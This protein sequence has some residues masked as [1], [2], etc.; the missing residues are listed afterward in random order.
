MVKHLLLS[1]NVVDQSAQLV[2]VIQW[3]VK[4]TVL[5]M[6]QIV[7][8]IVNKVIQFAH[9]IAPIA[10]MI[11]L[12]YN[13]MRI[14]IYKWMEAVTENVRIFI[15]LAILLPF[16]VHNVFPFAKN[17]QMEMIV[18]IV[19][20][21]TCYKVI[22]VFLNVRK[23]GLK[24]IQQVFNN[25]LRA[26]VNARYVLIQPNASIVQMKIIY[27]LIKLVIIVALKITIRMIFLLKFVHPVFPIASNAQME[28][29][30]RIVMTLTF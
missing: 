7:M 3:Q 17:A 8:I 16:S 21:L 4:Q 14:T 1:V 26:L 20:I 18:R 6:Q 2:S 22:Y 28:Q 24:I 25:A 11:I 12:A 13:V 30:V 9:L 23:A 29:I 5:F 15:T 10:L 19:M 27:N